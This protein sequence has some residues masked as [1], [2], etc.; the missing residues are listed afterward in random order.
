MEQEAKRS[1]QRAQERYEDDDE[2]SKPKTPPPPNFSKTIVSTTSV[3]SVFYDCA[4][5]VL[6]NCT[7]ASPTVSPTVQSHCKPVQTLMVSFQM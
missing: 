6:Y 7:T 2:V 5:R 4:P 1:Q 3:T